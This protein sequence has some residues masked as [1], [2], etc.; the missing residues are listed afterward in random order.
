VRAP[1]RLLVLTDASQTSGRPL[2]DVVRA[3][4]RG[5]AR[6]V[7]LREKQLPGPVRAALGARI[8]GVV[9]DA[10]GTFLA[11]GG[12]DDAHVPVDGVHLAATDP[13]P[14][15]RPAIVGRSCHD[16][17]ALRRAAAEGC[18]YATLSPIFPTASKP[19]YGPPLGPAALRDAPLP[20][21]ALGGVDPTGA[22]ACVDA[23]A[24]GVAVMGTVMRA[25]DPA[26]VVRD[27]LVVMHAGV[28]R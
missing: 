20:V 27:L 5:G 2:L 15:A 10:G 23:G 7:V 4:V 18:T 13:F 17:D 14:S 12:L 9:H 25:P 3:A 26:A 19:G 28:A 16:A 6:A 11:A 8:A 21:F 1:D 24:R 22:P